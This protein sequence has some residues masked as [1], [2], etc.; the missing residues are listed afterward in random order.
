M[1]ILVAFGLLVTSA[2]FMQHFPEWALLPALL[3]MWLAFQ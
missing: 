3:C 1:M 2:V